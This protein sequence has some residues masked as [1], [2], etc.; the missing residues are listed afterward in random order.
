MS[1]RNR[2]VKGAIELRSNVSKARA[3]IEGCG[4]NDTH[5]EQYMPQ[6]AAQKDDWDDLLKR[7]N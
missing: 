6:S 4:F 3:F 1:P 7:L 2:R 5:P